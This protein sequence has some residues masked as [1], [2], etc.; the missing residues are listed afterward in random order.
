MVVTLRQIWSAT[1]DD[2]GRILKSQ[3][4]TSSRNLD[5][6]RLAVARL[7]V[8][9]RDLS[10][11]EIAWVEAQSPP[12]TSSLEHSKSS[13]VREDEINRRLATHFESLIQMYKALNDKHRTKT[14]QH[15]L[16]VL[17]GFD[18]PVTSSAYF[19]GIKGVGPSVLKEIDQFV[20]TGRTDRSDEL[21]A[22]HGDRA[23]VIEL[24]EGVYGI[25][26]VAAAHFYAEGVRTI[27][28]LADRELNH[29]QQIGLKYYYHFKERIPRS[30]IDEF[31]RICTGIFGPVNED[32]WC[33]AGSYRRLEPNSG[34]IDL[35]VKATSRI[36]DAEVA[37]SALSGI[38]GASREP[39]IV[40]TLVLGPKKFMGV[41]K[42]RDIYRRIDI[43]VFEP[44]VW[45]YAL[46][47][48]TGSDRLNILM[49]VRANEFGLELS[50]YGLRPPRR[51][52]STVTVP[53]MS[54]EAQIFAFL[55][56][57]YLRP[58]ERLRTLTSLE[59]I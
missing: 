33:V 24:L 56:L 14:F 20:T 28:Q 37:F 32:V 49:R 26:H 38:I 1:I 12:T 55:R 6:D 59:T 9:S 51:G 5:E 35:V 4:L 45:P 46:L 10:A 21:E 16:D 11:E 31:V 13:Y 30:E 54:N 7:Y 53:E 58:E 25:G 44:S 57:K 8:K 39:I 19:Q 47:Y 36:P 23:R 22:H 2:L 50:E 27:E 29:S 15:A 3:G 40:E 48:N 18:A 52:G 34:D 43:R 42:I 17:K 41:A